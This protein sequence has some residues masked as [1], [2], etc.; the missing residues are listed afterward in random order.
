MAWADG[1]EPVGDALLAGDTL[2]SQGVA[3]AL[4]DAIH[5][6]LPVEAR[7]ARAA[8]RRD[9]HLARLHDLASSNRFAAEPVWRDYAAFLAEGGRETA[10]R[11]LRREP[12]LARA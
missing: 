6:H 9:S 3:W 12:V 7:L 1:A 11:T 4:S 10:A 2:C 8:E 5:L